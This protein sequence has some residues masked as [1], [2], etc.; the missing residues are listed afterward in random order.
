MARMSEDQ[1]NIRAAEFTVV[2]DNGADRVIL[3]SGPDHHASM[4]LLDR[5]GKRWAAFTIGGGRGDMPGYVGLNI[6][7]A[8]SVN[9]ARFGTAPGGRAM[10]V[11]L[12]DQQGKPRLR[13]QVAED[14]TPSIELLDADGNVTW[15]A[16]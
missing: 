3:Q 2:G 11:L 10:Q 5:D 1:A 4:R 8:D 15:R 12:N 6:F 13:L 7:N 16:G 9:I 14:G